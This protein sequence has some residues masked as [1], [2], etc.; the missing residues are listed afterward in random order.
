MFAYVRAC[1]L[2]QLIVCELNFLAL[3]VM[4]NFWL[5]LC[6][7]Y[8]FSRRVTGIEGIEWIDRLMMRDCDDTLRLKFFLI[9]QLFAFSVSV[10]GVVRYIYSS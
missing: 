3:R 6:V 5:D 1:A 4:C 7:R 10:S 8:K 2:N 9:S